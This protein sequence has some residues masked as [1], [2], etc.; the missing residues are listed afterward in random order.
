MEVFLRGGLVKLSV[1]LAVA[2]FVG[3]CGVFES[4]QGDEGGKVFDDYLAG[5]ISDLDSATATDG[6]S[7]DILNNFME[8]LYRL[9]EDNEPRP[10]IAESVEVT[11]DEKT[12]T[13]E[14]RDDARWSN[15]DPVTSQDFKYAWLKAMSPETGGLYAFLLTD[16]IAG[17][18]EYNA[19]DGSAGDVRIETPDE[20]TL[21]VELAEPTP[22]F[23]GLTALP[24]YFPQKESFVEE[25]GDEYA[26]NAE[27]LLANGPFEVS[28]FQ[29]SSRVVLEKNGDYWDEENVDL[30]R[31]NVGIIK[32]PQT[33]LNLYESDELDAVSLDAEAVERLGGSRDFTTEVSFQTLILYM[34]NDD[35]ALGNENIRRALQTGFDR[36]AYVDSILGGVSEPA[37]GLIPPGMAGPEGETFREATGDTV[38]EF[39]PEEARRMYERGVEELGEEPTITINVS[40]SE[41]YQDAG[42]FLQ[43]QWEENLGADIKVRA[44]PFDSLLEQ[45]SS[46]EYQ[47]SA[48]TW[49]A[50]YNDPMNYL[51][52]YLSDSDFN[53]PNYENERFDDL[54]N[55]AKQETDPQSRMEMLEEAERLLLEEDAAIAPVYYVEDAVLTKP[56]VEGYASHPYGP[57]I[58]Y[59]YVS[60]DE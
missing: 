6:Y 49:I 20:K 22:F 1:L 43:G 29:P 30:D 42:T 17:G 40:D 5:D 4:R 36:E 50:D 2:F 21:V 37:Y 38:P 45:A 11:D 8:G 31:V 3:G 27:N 32:E 19:G 35:E 10:A 7:F 52:L 51:D 55:G 46:G 14:L 18:A 47:I 15:G 53:Y 39:D 9:D 41:E 48:S 25:K 54:I 44:L 57:S 59:K 23:L 34:N 33:A 26:Q 12:Y 56:A 13:F 28:E 58:D 16:Y 24:A 60:L